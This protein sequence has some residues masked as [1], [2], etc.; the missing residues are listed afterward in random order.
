[1]LSRR[2]GARLL[3]ITLA[4]VGVGAAVSASAATSP[5]PD[6]ITDRNANFAAALVS[7]NLASALGTDSGVV[8]QRV[9]AAGLEVTVSS[10]PNATELA[11]VALVTKTQAAA[12]SASDIDPTVYRVPITFRVVPNSLATLTKLTAQLTDDQSAWAAKGIIFSSWGPDLDNDVVGLRLQTYNQEA[13]AALEAAYG[14]VLRVSAVS[15]TAA[16]STP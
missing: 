12:L 9:T 3:A 8:G 5:G 6:F 7:N 2:T 16:P 10:E 15:E 4:T 13:A 1:M 14:H 11:A